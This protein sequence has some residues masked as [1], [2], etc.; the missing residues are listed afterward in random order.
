MNGKTGERGSVDALFLALIGLSV[1]FGVVGGQAV[2][3]RGL[4]QGARQLD[5]EGSAI[6]CADERP[7]P[8]C[9][10]PESDHDRGADYALC[11]LQRHLP[12]GAAWPEELPACD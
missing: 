7:E 4:E 10:L 12:D 6:H 8:D 2:L 1:A 11:A 5:D 9:V 3:V